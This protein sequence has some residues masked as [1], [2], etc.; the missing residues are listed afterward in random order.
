MNKI[1]SA[2]LVVAVFVAC[3]MLTVSSD[4]TAAIGVAKAEAKAKKKRH[5]G[6]RIYGPRGGF[7]CIACH[8]FK[9]ARAMMEYPSLAGQDKKYMARQ[10]MDI[11][12]GK[13]IGSLDEMG[14]P[15][16]AG[17]RGVLLTPDGEPRMT[18]DM[19]QQVAEWLSMQPVSPRI[20]LAEPLAPE[21]IKEGKRLY[22][23]LR[24]ATCHGRDGKKP[25]RSYPYVAGQKKSYLV[26]QITDIRDKKRVNARSKMMGAMIRRVT[27]EEIEL[28]SDFLSQVDRTK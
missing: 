26:T 16:T 20:A 17:M 24:C 28:I 18:E 10:I 11:M 21:R 4:P 2:A 19:A 3:G 6:R 22:K 12:E 14:K 1:G 27:D 15:R 25:L 8:G 9:G 7:G 23:K 5:P 13:R